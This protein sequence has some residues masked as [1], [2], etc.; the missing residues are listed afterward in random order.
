MGTP[1]AAI[2]A[3]IFMADFEE[4]HLPTLLNS[5]NSQILTWRRYVDDT[6]TIES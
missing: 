4:K 2:F 6:F 5:D 1:L 3:E